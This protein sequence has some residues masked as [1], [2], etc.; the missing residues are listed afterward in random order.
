[1]KNYRDVLLEHLYK[2][3]LPWI[4][5]AVVIPKGETR[6]YIIIKQTIDRELI[7][8]KIDLSFSDN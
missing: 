6:A 5:F 7:S 8:Q 2:I 3:D 4:S 1:M